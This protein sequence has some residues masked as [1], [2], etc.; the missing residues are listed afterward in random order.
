MDAKPTGPDSSLV[1]AS[2]SGASPSPVEPI[3]QSCRAAR[4]LLIVQRAVC[5][6]GGLKFTAEPCLKAPNAEHAFTLSS[7]GHAVPDAVSNHVVLPT[8]SKEKAIA[9][10]A[11]PLFVLTRFPFN[12]DNA[13]A[14]DLLSSINGR[15]PTES[16][17]AS[18]MPWIPFLRRGRGARPRRRKR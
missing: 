10:Q 11:M 1:P 6:V 15:L 9:V 2:G 5:E 12:H 18:L 14:P 16:V 8:S 7:E 13:T 4:S 3:P 17:R